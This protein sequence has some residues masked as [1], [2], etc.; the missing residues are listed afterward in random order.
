M[1]LQGKHVVISG[2]SKG[3]GRALA[4]RFAAE[5]A[6][7]A[8]CARSAQALEAV[9]SELEAGGADIVAIPCDISDSLSV[10]TFVEGVIGRWGHV[11]ILI[12]NASILGPRVTVAEYPLKEWDE[13]IQT[14][15]HGSFFM[16]RLLVPAMM[17]RGSG[18]IINVSSSVG[19]TGRKQWGAYAVSKFALEG[20]TQ[21]LAEELKPFNIRVNSVNP[22]PMATAMRRSAYPQEDPST[23]R[24]PEQLTEVFVYL[25]SADG[26]GISGQAFDAATYIANPQVRT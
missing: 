8:L 7:L 18:A 6:R 16:T 23:L 22:G 21:V 25:A 19:R 20:L 5:G 26:K 14:N 12:N 17:Q 9:R 15:V 13:V 3:L 2:A 4:H 11:D 24:T 10:R 1:R